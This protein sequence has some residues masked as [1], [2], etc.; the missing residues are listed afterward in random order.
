M[1]ENAL[2]PGKKVQTPLGSMSHTKTVLE[3]FMNEYLSLFNLDS[4][5]LIPVTS[6]T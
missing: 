3:I 4:R 1:E 6:E 5:A 2:A